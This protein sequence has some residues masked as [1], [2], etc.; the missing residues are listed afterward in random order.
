MLIDALSSSAQ[1]ELCRPLARDGAAPESA[2]ER[3][4]ANL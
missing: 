3:A 2:T 4:E 1:F